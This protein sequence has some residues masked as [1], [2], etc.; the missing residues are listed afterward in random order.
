MS[1]QPISPNL[2]INIEFV[3]YISVFDYYDQAEARTVKKVMIKCRDGEYISH[4]LYDDLYPDA[5]VALG[6]RAP[7]TE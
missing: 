6:L 5:C 4:I 2:S 1:M 3:Q 7:G